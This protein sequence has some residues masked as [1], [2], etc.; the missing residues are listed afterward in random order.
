[1]K[2]MKPTLTLLTAL[3]LTSPVVLAQ[4]T[5]LP[6]F[7]TVA[8]KTP[9]AVDQLDQALTLARR[10]L[11]FVQRSRPCPALA[12][13]LKQLEQRAATGEADRAELCQ[14]VRQLRRQI[15]FS[16][17]L[18]DFDRLL[19]N[20]CP[21]P[22]YSHQSRQYLG[23]YSRPGP[24]LV[25]LDNWK[26]SP[27]ETPLLA[28]RLPAGTVM[29]P[30]LSFDARRVGFAF[31]D[32]TPADPNLRQFF[33][34][35]V[36]I[37][38]QGLRQLTGKVSDRLAGAEGRQTALIE[39]FDPCYL[40]DGGIAFVSTRTQTHIRCQYGGRYF[41]NFL[42]HRAD[43]NGENIRPLS[44][45]E[46]PEWEPSVLDD[47]RIVYSRWDYT[48]RHS[49]HFQSPWV[50]RPDG[51]GT[52]NVYGNL[53]R[54]PINT[55]EPRQ[56]PGS[57][58]IVCTAMAHHGYTAGS[59]VLVDPRR[60]LDGL[61]PLDRITPE[62]AFPETEGWPEGAYANPFPLSEDLFLAAYTPDKLAKEGQV[63]A[64]NA[65]GIYLVDTLGGRELIY[66]DPAMSCF[67][68]IPVQ[69]RPRPPVLPSATAE[70]AASETQEKAATGMGVFYVE[71]VYRSTQPIAAGS[72]K[73]VRVVR[74]FPQTVESPP[75]RSITPYEMPKQIVG[76]APVGEDGSV[77]FRAPAGQPLFFQLRDENGMAVMTMRALV[78]LQA[79][80]R[81]SCVGCHEP[82]H[83]A[84]VEV[85]RSRIRENSAVLREI[86][87]PP[88]LP[89][90]HEF[91]YATVVHALQPPVGPRYEGGLS[92][93]RTVQPVLDRYCIGCHGLERTDGD[94]DLLGILEPV[95]FPR[96]QW[97]GPNKM[98]VSRAYRSLVTPEGL[99]KVAHA[100]MET[101]YS[102]PKDYFAHAG[103]LAKLLLAGHPDKDGR[104][105]VRLDRESFQRIVDWLDLN[106]V[107]YGDYSWNKLE[108]REPSPEGERGLREE[109]RRRFGPQLAEQPLA[110]LVN[111]A[112]PE[113]SRI[114]QAPLAA[115]A[116]GWG[117]WPERAWRSAAEPGYVHMRE[118]VRGAIA[119]LDHHDLAGTC[120][121][122][123]RCLCDCCW[124]RLRNGQDMVP[125]DSR[126]R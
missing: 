78:Y 83:V 96:K 111:V 6:Q 21:P 32:H 30:D 74:V 123:D 86:P 63:Q 29:H 45:A 56:V 39:D 42:L 53:T 118:L 54:N 46:A 70:R 121:R 65:Y 102:T 69:P 71:N 66:R 62:I 3:L 81:A 16:H 101:D 108:W 57:P 8:D 9:A 97:P 13:R 119:S 93:A 1:M 20:K 98:T 100:D 124:V 105:L 12:S 92:F 77:A 11:D 19:V 110:A 59:I 104:P 47:G 80:E 117:L 87:R 114:L 52:A 122:P 72:I 113:E 79:G 84:P 23:R 90:S 44:F 88:Q 40:P 99:V 34:W 73:S 7:N 14:S 112:L 51:T 25:V 36:G 5:T 115:E 89:N 55:A 64:E 103:R 28:G 43:A 41:A 94:I 33:L 2:N 67:S 37:D 126:N 82:R 91:G 38:R 95:T 24:G 107:C 4:T 22:A 27:R 75:S 18:L 15:I 49:Y 26:E 17:P 125:G 60:G 10:T 109:I 68:P 61:A 76:T 48:N 106:A 116:G 31:C 58:K 50:T 85:A 120:G 35:E